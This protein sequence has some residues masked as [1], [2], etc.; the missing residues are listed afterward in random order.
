MKLKIEINNKRPVELTDYAYSMISLA[1]EYNR[2]IG[3]GESPAVADDVKLYVC[4]VRSGSIITELCAAA[5][6]ALPLIEHSDTIIE[7][8]KHLKIWMDWLTGKSS[9]QPAD[10]DKTTLQNMHSIVDPVAKDHG[11][12]INIGAINIAG[13]VTLQLNLSSMEANAL[14]NNVR[15]HI[16]AMKEPAT[17]IHEQVVMY[18]AQARNQTDNKSGDKAR[19]ESIYKGDVKVRFANDQLKEEMLHKTPFPFSHAFVVDV[20]VETIEGRPVLY[21]VLEHH[22]TIERDA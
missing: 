12:Q 4:E 11:S 7:Y 17:G 5:P 8:A 2:K 20:A 9:E 21:K 19:I 10:L 13:D 18:W 14:Q 16:E 15:R 22:E 1:N 6:F 3:N